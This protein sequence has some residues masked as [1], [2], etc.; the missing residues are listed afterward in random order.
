MS[1][2][3]IC[4]LALAQEQ[5]NIT[6]YY[7]SPNGSYN[8]LG[9]NRLAVDINGVAVPTEF[10]A[11]ANGDAH[12]GRSLIIGAGGGSG[13][14]YDEGATTADGT[15]L[16]KGN[17]GIGTTAPAAKMHQNSGNATATYHKFTA[18]TTTG[19]LSTDGFDVGI[20]GSGNAELIQ[21]ENLS[22]N[23]ST[24]N[25][26]R[27]TI[28]ANGDVGI[29]DTTPTAKLDVNGGIK[30]GTTSTCNAATQGT[31]R[32]NSGAVEYCNTSNNWVTLGGLGTRTIRSSSGSCD[33][34]V[35]CQ[36][37][38]VLVGGGCRA[39]GSG[40][41]W[42]GSYPSG[43]TW[44]CSAWTCTGGAAFTAYAVCITQ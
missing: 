3:S 13:Y 28:L 10:A 1:F 20:D 15:L 6:T 9:T 19:L 8:E 26:N 42:L 14:A 29:G 17:V 22:M 40:V 43:N 35:S 7:P 18:G 23:F 33:A 21:R 2:C 31:M 25:T 41:G 16:V 24:N 36:S 37:G 30:L 12:I 11:M 38:E 44:Q 4:V 34:S 32:Y 39:S 27:M 5:I